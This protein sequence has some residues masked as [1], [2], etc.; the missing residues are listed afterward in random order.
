MIFS[1]LDMK[2][3]VNNKET[4]ISEGSN[5]ASLAESLGIP[6]NGMV[7]GV[8]IAVNNVMIPRT[9]W[10]EQELKEGDNVVVIRAAC[11]G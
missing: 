6:L 7:R 8:A 1:A 5:V 11:G 4:L 2:L 10:N 9:S 3:L